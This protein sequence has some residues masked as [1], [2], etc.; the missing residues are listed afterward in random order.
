MNVRG[1]L[2][3]VHGASDRQAAVA[4][5]V[6]RIEGQLA[7]AGMSFDVVASRWGEA[8]GARLDRIEAA[9]PG[10]E[11]VAAAFPTD[12]V[13]MRALLG[14]GPLVELDRLTQAPPPDDAASVSAQPPRWREA[15]QLLE[16]CQTEVGAPTETVPTPDGE[17][18]PLGVACRIAATVVRNSPEYAVAHSSA[19]PELQLVAAAGRA[20]AA[21]VA[22]GL[23]SPVEIVETV[24]VRIAEA[25][26]G[27]AGATILAGYLGIDVGPDLKR[28]ATDVLIPHRARLMREAG[29]GAADVLVYQRNGDLIR[30]VVARSIGEALGRG[31]PVIALGNSLGG[32]V[33]VDTLS[34]PNAPRPDLLVTVGSQ[35]PMLA[36]IDALDPLR[37]ADSPPPFQ[38]WLN[39]YDRRD[40]LSFVAG[41]VWPGVEGITDREVDGGLGFPDSH[42][43]AYLSN[44]EVYR[45]IQEHPALAPH[46]EPEPEP[47]GRPLARRFPMRLGT[48]SRPVLLL[49]GVLEGNAYVDLD[50]EL[51]AH[52]GF[53]RMRTTLD[54]IDSWRIEGPWP[55]I[56]AIGVRR[57]IRDGVISFG[58]NHKGGVR[59]NFRQPV[60]WGFLSVPA[61]Y[62]TVGDLDGFAAALSGRG[63]PGEDAR[64]A[65]T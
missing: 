47:D 50:G 14:G 43:V 63:I 2:V 49:F 6:Q 58:G 37:Q 55:W 25:V 62:V 5:H 56:T 64:P 41:P 59:L 24:Q 26:L 48:L 36:A 57:G 33:L 45:H 32:I 46:E 52:F 3:Y 27:A 65:P 12:A 60:K 42:G 13:A 7:L 29:L 34:A 17:T 31:G 23:S 30:R 8:E 53:F 39:V 22:V 38:P 9:L 51:D 4:D 11:L 28:W 40:F 16:I 61:L 19:V 44:P 35:A 1:T 20:V 10:T 54:N 18:Q 15:D 21:T